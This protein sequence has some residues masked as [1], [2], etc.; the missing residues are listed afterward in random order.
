MSRSPVRRQPLGLNRAFVAANR[1]RL[2]IVAVKRRDARILDIAAAVRNL[3]GSLS[4]G[5][6]SREIEMVLVD[7]SQQSATR[8]LPLPDFHGKTRRRREMLSTLRAGLRDRRRPATVCVIARNDDWQV[9]EQ[10]QEF[11]LEERAFVSAIIPVMENVPAVLALEE[12]EVLERTGRIFPR[13]SEVDPLAV[14]H[15]S[16]LDGRA[17]HAPEITAEAGK[18][19]NRLG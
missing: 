15:R 6:I 16:N 10:D 3:A 19:G 11:I 9:R 18:H 5:G 1:L 12:R 14:M 4:M 2:E 8:R 17:A 7:P 13:E